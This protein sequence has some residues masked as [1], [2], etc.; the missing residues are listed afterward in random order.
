MTDRESNHVSRRN[1]RRFLQSVGITGI[2][3]V[4]AGCTGGEENGDNGDNGNGDP[5]PAAFEV[6][7]LDSEEVTVAEGDAAEIGATVENTGE[8]AGTQTVELTLDGERVDS[9]DLELDAGDDDTVSFDVDTA[10]RGGN[11]YD[12]TISTDDDDAGGT[13]IVTREIGILV[14]SSTPDYRHESVPAG[15]QALLELGDELAEESTVSDVTVDIIDTEGEHAETEPVEFPRDVAD[16]SEYDVLVFNN[17]NGANDPESTDPVVMDEEQEAAF[18]AFIEDGGGFV[19]IHS[20]ADAQPGDSFYIETLGGYFESHP[21]FQEGTALVTDRTHPSTAHLPLEWELEEE[22]YNYIEDPRGDVHVLCSADQTSYEGVGYDGDGMQMDVEGTHQ[23]LV[24]CQELDGGARSW[25]TGI[26]H[27]PELYEEDEN[28]RQ[29]LLGGIKWAAG[30]EDGDATGTVW[31]SYEMTTLTTDTES[32]SV[33]DVASDGRVFYVDRGE[34]MASEPGTEAVRVID[35]EMDEPSTVI[36][37]PVGGEEIDGRNGLTGLVLDPDFE[38]NGWLY[39]T[40]ARSNEKI[41]DGEEPHNRLSRFT[42]E[43]GSIDRETETVILEYPMQ[44]EVAAH[45]AGDIRWGPDGEQL[46]VTIGDDT[47]PA[48]LYAAIDERDGQEHL[49]A[50]RTAANTADLRGS[51]LR[52]VPEEDGS[53]SI[54]EDNLFTEGG[55]YGDEVDDGTVRP[56]I[57]AMGVRNP[58]R[59]AVDGETGTLYWGDYGPDANS[60]DDERGPPAIVEYNRT[61]E[62]GFFGWPYVQGP[63]IPYRDYDHETGEPG[64]IF[65]PENPVN[66][67]PNNDG[68]TELPSAI[69]AAITSPYDWDALLDYPTEW[70]Q[71]VPYDDIDEVPFQIT[72]GSAMQGPVY[73]HTDAYGSGALSEYFDGKAFIMDRGEGWIRYVTYDDEGEPVAVEPFLDETFN[74]PMDLR[75][76]PDG[77]LYLIEWGSGYNGPNDDGG[78]YRIE[79]TDD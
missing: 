16:L 51:I 64:D 67:S 40:Y 14:N 34:Y 53:Y 36:D 17:A 25:Y 41:E 39:L 37:L 26:G 79:R 63:N 69:G 75:V 3:G 73:R 6:T 8:E 4:L 65:D 28:Y 15:N 77:A 21:E 27:A 38:D 31:D 35:P 9:T 76:G 24:W 43:D 45:A 61:D 46:Y 29:H 62:P 32:P 5:S 1:R 7:A 71:Y 42:V 55:G 66:E 70:S 58:Y 78:I 2:A 23:P 13:L 60:W 54:P 56:E 49:D 74:H 48:D 72:G 18:Q 11:E 20:A 22:W 33:L 19:G 50:Q 44:R 47:G 12:F 10:D 52:I 30:L 68:L 57:F 59:I